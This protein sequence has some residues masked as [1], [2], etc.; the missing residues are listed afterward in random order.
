L[1]NKYNDWRRIVFALLVIFFFFELNNISIMRNRQYFCIKIIRCC[2]NSKTIIRV[3]KSLYNN[4]LDFSVNN[5]IVNT[6]KTNDIC[7]RYCLYWK[8]IAFLVKYLKILSKFILTLVSWEN[9]KLV[10]FYIAYCDLSSNNNLKQ[11]LNKLIITFSQ[12]K[13]VNSMR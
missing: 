4:I 1:S 6:F 5:L 13:S 2:N 9:K 12:N 7:K 11:I 3:L 10:T 8:K